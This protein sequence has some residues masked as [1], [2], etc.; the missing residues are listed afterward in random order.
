MALV[1]LAAIVF[2]LN[3]FFAR[4]VYANG[5]NA[6]TLTFLSKAVGVPALF[7]MHRLF[8]NQSVPLDKSCLKKLLLCSLGCAA[9]PVLLYSSYPYISSGMATT[10]HWKPLYLQCFQRFCTNFWPSGK[11]VEI[12]APQ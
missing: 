6:W 1:I 8:G 3:P 4:S 2:G 9:A 11:T 7:L 5:G 12:L 10:L